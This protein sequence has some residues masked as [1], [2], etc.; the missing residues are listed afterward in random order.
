MVYVK[1]LIKR[2][3]L[4]EFKRKKNCIFFFSPFRGGKLIDSPFGVFLNNERII[5]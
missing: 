2:I 4:R 5:L 3:S 1:I